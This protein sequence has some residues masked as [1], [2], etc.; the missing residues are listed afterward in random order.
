M[1]LPNSF[2]EPFQ[3]ERI[4]SL[5]RE[6]HREFKQEIFKLEKKKIKENDAILVLNLT[7]NVEPNYIGGA[8]FLEI[9]KAWE[10]GKK[11]FLWNKIPD[12]IFKDEL[13]GIDIVVIYGNINHFSFRS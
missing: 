13:L 12:N 8:T 5:G 1:T 6:Q 3:E 4:K 7:K 10:M 2:E 9:F 11:I